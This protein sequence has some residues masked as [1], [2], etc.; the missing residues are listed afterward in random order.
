VRLAAPA[1]AVAEM[2]RLTGMHR[3]LDTFPTVQ[4]AMTGPPN[5]RHRHSGTTRIG[6]APR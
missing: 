1:P 6:S 2:L 5:G 4:A 3:Q